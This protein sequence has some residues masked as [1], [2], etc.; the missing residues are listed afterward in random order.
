[1]PKTK[2]TQVD[3][4]FRELLRELRL[5]KN[6]TQRQV[7]ERLGLPQSYVSKYDTGQRRLD[8]METVLVCEALGTNVQQFA[9]AFASRLAKLRRAKAS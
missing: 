6:L 7:A 8:F 2:A 1:V 4:I 9:A 5:A 3:D